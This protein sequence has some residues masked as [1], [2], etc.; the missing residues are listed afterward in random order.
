MKKKLF[1]GRLNKGALEGSDG[2]VLKNRIFYEYISEKMPLDYID[3]DI[4]KEKRFSNILS[5]GFKLFTQALIGGGMIIGSGGSTPSCKLIRLLQLITFRKPIWVLGLGGNMHDYIVSNQLHIA[6]M[7]K[8]KAILVEGKGMVSVLQSAGLKQ[9]Y[10]TPNFKNIDYLPEKK[11]R[12]DDVVKFV[13]FA[14][15]NRAKG[16]NEIFEAS[17]ILN[18][19]GLVDK[20]E[21]HFYGYKAADYIEEFELKINESGANVIYDGARDIRKKETY[22]ELS[23]Y[24]VML[25]PTYWGD[26]GFPATIVDAFISGLPVI[27]TNWKCNGELVEDGKNGFLIPIKDSHALAEKMEWFIKNKCRILGMAERMQMMAMNYD[28]KH[29]LSDDFLKEIGLM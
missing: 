24:D 3:I 23:L 5:F 8:S 18:E 9:V 28:I 12:D 7:S 27:A 10:Y 21:V 15:V 2:V 17:R 11:S 1:I 14:R 19:K 6:I 29:I 26:E 16:C 4:L 20:F 13:F 25:F 22:K